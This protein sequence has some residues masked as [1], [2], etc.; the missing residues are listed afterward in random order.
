[1]DDNRP[2]YLLIVAR[3]TFHELLVTAIVD[4]PPGTVER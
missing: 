4:T 1:L 2:Y 3:D